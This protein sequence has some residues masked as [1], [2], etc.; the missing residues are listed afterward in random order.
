MYK[1]YGQETEILADIWNRN[2]KLNFKQQAT[3]SLSLVN[4]LVIKINLVTKVLA[5][6]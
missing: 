1:Y 3:L 6:D 5:K 2:K 4:F